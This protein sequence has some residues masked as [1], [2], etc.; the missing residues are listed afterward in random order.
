MLLVKV[1]PGDG[2]ISLATRYTG[3]TATA[4][5]IHRA[6]PRLK[7][8][9]RDRRVRI[10]LELLRADLRL[11]AARTLF[12][13]DH[14]SRLGFR[15]WILAPFGEGS[16]SWKWLGLFFCGADRSRDLK[17]ANPEMS[18]HGLRRARPFHIPEALLLRVFRE[19]P[20]KPEPTPTPKPMPKPT[21]IRATPTPITNPISPPLP[22][23]PSSG[24]LE[25]GVDA[26]GPFAIYRLHRGEALYSAVVVRFT[27]Q[28][29][30]KQVNATA[31]EIARRSGITD[32]TDIPI[33][34]P[35][36]I[37]LDL[38]LPQYLPPED[39]RRK[40]WEESRKELAGF[41][42]VVRD[43]N[44]SGVQIILDAGHGGADTGAIVDGVWESTYVYDILCRVR[45]RLED[46]TGARVWTTIEDRS[47]GFSIPRSNRL[48]ED[49]DQL[50]LTHPRYG[51]E[52]TVTGVH[53]RWYLTNDIILSRIPKK[54]PRNKT[55]FISFHA[56]SLHPSV[57][58]AMVYVPA[59]YLRPNSYQA[60][61]R[62]L[63]SRRE[64]R[65]HPTVR[66]SNTFKARAE[67]SSRRMAAKIVERLR[68]HELAV[69]PNQPI[70]G[71]IIRGKRSWVP[72]VLRYS[73]AQN[74]LLIEICNM[75]NT[76]DRR[77]LVD[78]G[79]RE[80]FAQAVVE[81]IVN[82]FRPEKLTPGTSH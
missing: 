20:P 2:W 33:S 23:T 53:L 77:Q 38:L 21:T 48:P 10:P 50:L 76:E 6:N 80:Q 13:T 51:L 42:E 14:R 44:L 37:P 57:R 63:S 81:G 12:P 75:S 34:H 58:G 66:L 11:K 65:E 27:G 40:A 61:S 54:T 60:S 82:A 67:A 46:H 7:H 35:I 56:D 29:H 73:L 4:P 32:V 49:R 55:V 22:S 43:E 59:R 31:L 41:L 39:P 18:Q 79:W 28:L 26:R 68:E 3:T 74:A 9:L 69:H 47:R 70:R 15:H 25:Y 8:P 36:K 17:R 62:G 72:A 24:A 16:E 64:F 19:L 45:R 71:R 1:R 30:A 78:A 52:D 5:Q